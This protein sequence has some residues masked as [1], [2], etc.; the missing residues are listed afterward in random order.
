VL[1]VLSDRVAR[2]KSQGFVDPTAVGKD[3]ANATEPLS[4]HAPA[5]SRTRRQRAAS[6][7][8]SVSRPV[9]EATNRGSSAELSYIRHVV[10]KTWYRPK[11]LR[12]PGAVSTPN[13]LLWYRMT[14]THPICDSP[15]RKVR[16]WQPEEHQVALVSGRDQPADSGTEGPA[17]ERRLEPETPPVHGELIEATK[18][19]ATGCDSGCF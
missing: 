7:A 8:I 10:V 1:L 15:Y 9:P 13:R 11:K 5:S 16:A 3:L 4:L 6:F 19:R 14:E 2:G 18:H 12:S 17:C